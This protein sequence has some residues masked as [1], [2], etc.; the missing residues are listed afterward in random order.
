MELTNEQRKYLGLEL[1]EPSWERVEIPNNCVRPELSTG[2]IILY[3]DG[4]VLRK[5]ISVDKNGCY[6]EESRF[7]KTQDNRSMIAPITEKGKPKRLNGVNLQRCTSEGMYFRYKSGYV[8]LANYSTQQ[9][10]YSS[11]FA[12]LPAMSEEE[13]QNFLMQ[14]IVET[15]DAE[16]ARIHAFANASRRHCKFKEGDF[17]RFSIDRT[18]YGYGRV[19]LDIH[20]MRKSGVKFWDI[21]MG[22]PLVVSVY[23][24]ITENPSADIYTLEALKSCPSQFIM[25]NRFYYGEYEIV[26]YEPLPEDVD[27]PIMYGPSIDARDRNKIQFQRGRIYREIPLEGNTIIPGGFR[28]NGI[29][30]SLYITKNLLEAC[31][32]ADSNDPYWNRGPDFYWEDLRHPQYEHE[33]EQ[34]LRQMGVEF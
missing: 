18:H 17:F 21:L 32:E 34:V 26:G 7:L 28:N 13:L 27:Y 11:A 5:E 23:H 6:M 31:I 22:R 1:I 19:L 14:W 16:L 3:F 30:V 24:I 20:K 8:T 10:F 12:G 2:K 25:D 29:G 9:T 15:D 33:R 4:D